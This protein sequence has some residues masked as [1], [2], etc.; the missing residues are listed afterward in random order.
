M[1]I[2]IFIWLLI[3]G[4]VSYEITLYNNA[5]ISVVA[6]MLLLIPFVDLVGL[7]IGSAGCQVQM[8]IPVPVAEKKGEISV[9]FSLSGGRKF[10]LGGCRVLLKIENLTEKVSQKKKIS[11]GISA[12]KE[13]SIVY[14]LRASTCGRIR[15]ETEK[16]LVYGPFHLFCRKKASHQSETLT[17]LPEIHEAYVSV[18]RGTRFFAG[19]TDDYEPKAAGQDHSQIYQI[20]E[21]RPGDRLQMIHWKLTARN[22]ELYVKEASEPV[23]YSVGLFM[24][25]CQIE[26]TG[27]FGTEGMIESILSLSNALLEENCHHFI[28]WYD[29]EDKHLI[30]KKI[31][32]IEHIYEA[33]EYLLQIR[34]YKERVDLMSMYKEQYPYGLFATDIQIDLSGKVYLR[35]QEA[36]VLNQNKLKEDIGRLVLTV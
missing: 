33:T 1:I 10:F 2:Q 4:F 28:C 30:K 3:T 20:R 16:V 34:P 31:D 17:F 24:D 7:M 27:T 9:K 11:L 5:A 13:P 8:Q 19:E 35:G 32:Q 14:N 18:S 12:G 36:G 25:L 21:Y 15:V 23:S 22:N 26:K 6:V 29:A